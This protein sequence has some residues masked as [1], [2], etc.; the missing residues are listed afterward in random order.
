MI[1]DPNSDPDIIIYYAHGK[2]SKLFKGCRVN[3][4]D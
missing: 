1:D 4:L 3:I 2:L